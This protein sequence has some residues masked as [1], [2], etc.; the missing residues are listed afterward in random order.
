MRTNVERKSEKSKT[1]DKMHVIIQL[2][3]NRTE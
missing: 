1:E 3:S 2:H